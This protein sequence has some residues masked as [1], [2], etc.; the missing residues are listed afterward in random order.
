MSAPTYYPLIGIDQNGNE[1]SREWPGRNWEDAAE[2]LAL[3]YGFAEVLSNFSGQK[4]GG[5]GSGVYNRKP[6]YKAPALP[7]LN[8]SGKDTS[9][10]LTLADLLDKPSMI[11]SLG[12]V[13]DTRALI[14]T[15]RAHGFV[16]ELKHVAGK[17]PTLMMDRRITCSIGKP[18]L[19]KITDIVRQ[20]RNKFIEALEAEAAES[21]AT[22]STPPP[23]EDPSDPLKGKKLGDIML[24]MLPQMPTPFTADHLIDRLRAAEYLELAENRSRVLSAIHT[25]IAKGHVAKSG[26]AKYQLT[27]AFRKR[28]E[29]EIPANEPVVSVVSDPITPEAQ[30]N[31]LSLES[32]QPPRG[33]IEVPAPMET[34]PEPTGLASNPQALLIAS[35]LDLASQAAVGDDD[36][37]AL[38]VTLNDAR[39]Q[40]E[41]AMLA[42][43]DALSSIVKRVEDQLNKRA[44]ARK[45]LLQSLVNHNE[46]R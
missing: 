21:N 6:L 31:P 42:A 44:A 14:E 9:P 7:L 38:A 23:P 40:F 43:V 33:V 4:R 39:Q 32:F 26:Y 1:R 41:S 11:T 10:A 18:E 34:E 15:M 20:H 28:G 13:K 8:G 37:A 16:F 5:N 30:A 27:E 25:A 22:P 12:L 46:P 3:R 29:T 35:V 24:A 17:R 45:T 2:K 36:M 19:G